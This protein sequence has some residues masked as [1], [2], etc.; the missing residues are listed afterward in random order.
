MEEQDQKNDCAVPDPDCKQCGGRGWLLVPDGS[1][2]GTDIDC[3]CM[4]RTDSFLN[5]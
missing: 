5:S 3:D 4:K 2:Q 1:D